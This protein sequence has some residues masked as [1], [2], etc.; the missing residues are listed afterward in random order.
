M[1][2]VAYRKGD[3]DMASVNIDVKQMTGALGYKYS[4]SKR[5]YLYTDVAYTE[6]KVEAAATSKVKETQFNVGICHNF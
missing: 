1:A 4:L 2:S 5:T 6:L 3:F